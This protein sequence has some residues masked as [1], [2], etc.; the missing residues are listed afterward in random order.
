MAS[1]SA[2]INEIESK[3]ATPVETPLLKKP[4][5]FNLDL[6]S[7]SYLI[8]FREH[9]VGT[10]KQRELLDAFKKNS[11]NKNKDQV[12]LKINADETAE[13]LRNRELEE[14][15]ALINNMHLPSDLQMADINNMQTEIDLSH[16][17]CEQILND[18]IR[19]A[20]L[21]VNTYMKL[22]ASKP[23]S[24]CESDTSDESDDEFENDNENERNDHNETELNGNYKKTYNQLSDE[25][26]NDSDT[27]DESDESESDEPESD[28]PES[29]E[30]ESESDESESDEPESESDESESDEPEN[31]S[32]KSENDEPEND[33]ESDESDDNSNIQNASMTV[34]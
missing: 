10:P 26:I 27:S 30:P 12:N 29:D 18:L 6:D 14:L 13:D 34:D 3:I 19:E 24:I 28:E 17:S 11:L 4:F 2:L 32:D 1:V 22:E 7:S 8:R 25:G 16:Y 20:E 5:K 9:Y 33:D 23:N 31:E 15:E 21:E